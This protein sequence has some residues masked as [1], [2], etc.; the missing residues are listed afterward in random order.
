MKVV[1]ETTLGTLQGVEKQG[2]LAFHGIPYAAPP[3]GAL[4]WR[5]PQPVEPWAGIRPA[6]TRPPAPPQGGNPMA[7]VANRPRLETSEDCL[8]LDVWT[9]AC[10][11]ARRPVMVWIHGG[12]VIFGWGSDPTHDGA[13]LCTRG[14]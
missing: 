5:A 9:P 13:A 6:T 1:A 10:D 12:G 3:V 4:R 2:V 11:D 8:Y 14:D 7:M